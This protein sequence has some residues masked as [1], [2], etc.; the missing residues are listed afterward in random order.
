MFYF[1]ICQLFLPLYKKSAGAR[2]SA[3]QN[4]PFFEAANSRYLSLR[5]P[6]LPL[7]PFF[8]CLLVTFCNIIWKLNFYSILYVVC[9]GAKD[10]PSL[11]RCL[12]TRCWFYD[13]CWFPEKTYFLIE[14]SSSQ[15]FQ[16]SFFQKN[17]IRTQL[18]LPNYYV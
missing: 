1:F 8:Y 10:L 17:F 15:K 16:K 11:L 3:K 9:S 2:R 18:W 6:Y 13:I 12:S 7:A 4:A 5:S 14:F